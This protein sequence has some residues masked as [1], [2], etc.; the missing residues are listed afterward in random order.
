MRLVDQARLCVVGWLLCAAASHAQWLRVGDK[1]PPLRLGE[2]VK[3]EPIGDF[4]RG[5]VYVVDFWTTWSQTSAFAMEDLTRI[6]CE[7]APRGVAVIGVNVMDDPAN[8]LPFMQGKDAYMPGDRAMGYTVAIEEKTP[9]TDPRHSG[10]MTNDWLRASGQA[11]VPITFIVDRDRRIAWIGHPTWPAGELEDYLEH[12]VAG[13][14]TEDRAAELRDT[15]A[16]IADLT[17][18]VTSLSRSGDYHSAIEAMDRLAEANPPSR[19]D[20]AASR[21]EILLVGL[22][23]EERAYEYA[24]DAV[25]TYLRDDPRR[26]NYIAWMIVDEPKVKHRD[27]DVAMSLAERACELTQWRDPAILDTLAKACFDAGDRRRGLRLQEMAAKYAGGT[28]W[29]AEIMDR[30]HLYRT[31]VKDD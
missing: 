13:T 24:S 22:G 29:E 27:Y 9:G 18:T 31:I 5:T 23:E 11:A 2:I 12:V 1:A 19:R 30:L 20:R 4:E 16:R 26:L 10:A 21:L 8:V 15:W 14:L 28:R 17:N 3:G 25:K 7:F 6:Q